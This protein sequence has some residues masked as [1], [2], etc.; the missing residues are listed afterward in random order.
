[1]QDS[2]RASAKCHVLIFNDYEGLCRRGLNGQRGEVE[3]RRVTALIR[4]ERETHSLQK[5]FLHHVVQRPVQ[6]RVVQERAGRPQPAVEVHHLV[7]GVDVVVLRDLLHPAHH[8]ALQDPA[9]GDRVPREGSSG[10]RS[11][12]RTRY[13][14]PTPGANR[15]ES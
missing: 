14:T 10:H 6:G 13:S 15:L 12:T 4:V 9:G 7:V 1:M 5:D 8:H 3:A 11:Y 2:A